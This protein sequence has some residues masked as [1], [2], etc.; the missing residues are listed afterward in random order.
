MVTLA[1]FTDTTKASETKNLLEEQYIKCQ[2]REGFDAES[3]EEIKLELMHEHDFKRAQA[4]IQEAD[5]VD[6]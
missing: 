1:R 2:L 6:E 4:V 3:V 5:D